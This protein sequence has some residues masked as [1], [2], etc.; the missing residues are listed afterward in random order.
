MSLSQP[1]ATAH[2]SE[3]GEKPFW[4][5]YADLM[6]ALM[7]L[8]LV[9]MVTALATITKQSQELVEK[10]Q[11]GDLD[12]AEVVIRPSEP[13]LAK[14]EL[15]FAEIKAVC[16]QLA[17]SAKQVNTN[18]H[19]NCKLNRIDFGPFGQFKKDQY[20]LDAQGEAALHD[21]VPVILN[22][23]NSPL[24]QKW[25]KQV[26]IEGFTDT[27]GA[28]LYNLHLSLKR[29]EW[30]MC[31][32]LKNKASDKAT[33]TAEARQQIKQLFLAG[34]VAFNQ[35]Q[36]SKD[37]SRRI[38]LRLQFYGADDDKRKA[39]VDATKFQDDPKDKCMI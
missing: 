2:R 4:I 17:Q 18:L 32:L 25:L 20:T 6:T 11:K 23:A 36:A 8:F 10:A 29:S 9:I 39:H 34:G 1:H 22:T 31:T 7:I 12:K 24:G 13:E 35:A 16:E 33:L 27:D 3:D 28:Y 26:V 30:V 21:V 5:S 37:A 14:T 19:V 15:R 38:E